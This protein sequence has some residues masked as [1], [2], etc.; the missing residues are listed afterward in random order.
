MLKIPFSEANIKALRYGRFHH[1]DPR[2]QVRVEALYLRSPG[3]TNSESIRRC[4]SSKASCH[5]YLHA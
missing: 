4:G 5:R 2:V 1:P 3:V